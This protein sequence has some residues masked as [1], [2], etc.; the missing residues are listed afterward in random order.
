MDYI[1]AQTWNTTLPGRRVQEYG[2]SY[3]TGAMGAKIQP[4]PDVFDFLC[5]R[6]VELKLM[7]HKPDQLIINEY[8][9]G[10]GIG[11]H[12]DHLKYFGDEV[13][14]V[15]MLSDVVMIFDRE[16]TGETIDVLLERSSCAVL[17]GD[18]RYKWR[19]SI[20]KRKKD[21]IHGWTLIRSRRVSLTFRHM[22]SS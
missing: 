7:T 6:F 11:A 17:T 5:K 20:A 12:I 1:D 19:H 3:H 8:N 2:Y 15:S 21:T 9:P 10:Q 4:I 13:V 18:A 22:L 16:D 14:S